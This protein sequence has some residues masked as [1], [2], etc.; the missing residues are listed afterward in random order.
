ME[1]GLLESGGITLRGIEP[2]DLELF[3]KI[4]NDRSLWEI[5]TCNVPYSRFALKQFL[6]AQPSDIFTQG[7]LR[8]AV[9][10]KK[11]LQTIGLADLAN[12]NPIDGRAEIG[13]A[14]LKEFRGNGYGSEV[15]KALERYSKDILRMRQLC[16]YVSRNNNEQSRRLFSAN[17]YEE[18]AIL[19]QW[20]Y[21]KGEYEDLSVF[22]K[23]LE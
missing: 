1:I 19:P 5:G 4:E 15:L 7:E 20:H 22:S 21:Y 17:G 14:L 13:I 9:S 23:I 18:V 8:L 12:F 16:A 6:S 2:E 10:L 11:N 3:Y